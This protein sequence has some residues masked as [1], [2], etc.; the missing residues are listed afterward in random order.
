MVTHEPFIYSCFFRK[1]VPGPIIAQPKALLCRWF[2]V[3]GMKYEIFSTVLSIWSR[4]VRLTYNE[5]V[6]QHTASIHRKLQ[7]S[8]M[9]EFML[10][11]HEDP[12]VFE[13]FS[14]EEIQTIVERYVNWR[15]KLAEQDLLVGGAKLT[16]EGGRHLKGTSDSFTVVDGPF[17][18]AKEV[19]G[20]YFTIKAANYEDAIAIARECPHLEFGRIE[21]RELD[22][23]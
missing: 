9:S 5:S 13:G 14:P 10:V 8:V 6:V 15:D 16:D 23:D 19:M 12:K 17:S 4:P 20:G 21:L 7:E 1:T 11:L 2:E 22:P 3:V 18:E